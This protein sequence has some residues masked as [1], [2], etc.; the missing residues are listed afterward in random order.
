M[1]GF[2]QF[3]YSSNYPFHFILR[4]FLDESGWLQ[5]LRFSWAPSRFSFSYTCQSGHSW[6]EDFNVHN[7]LIG[8][9]CCIRSISPAPCLR[10]SRWPSHSQ[11]E[12]ICYG[13][14]IFIKTSPCFKSGLKCTQTSRSWYNY[15]VVDHY[16]VLT[17]QSKLCLWL[18]AVDLN[19]D[20]PIATCKKMPNRFMYGFF[21]NISPLNL[22]RNRTRASINSILLISSGI[23]VQ[24]QTQILYMNNFL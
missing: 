5:P 21:S 17:K 18:Q 2:R 22:C 7:R 12:H 8:R 19:P 1:I 15:C 16:V 9:N 11:P 20:V 3:H 6:S 13:A 24:N 4:A 23:H 10:G 14:D